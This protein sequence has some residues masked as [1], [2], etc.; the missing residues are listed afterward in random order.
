M[1]FLAGFFTKIGN[2]LVKFE[3]IVN[4]HSQKIHWSAKFN[5]FDINEYMFVAFRDEMAFVS[6]QLKV[7]I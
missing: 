4:Y 1:S 7:V 2:M 3:I 6:I 5:N